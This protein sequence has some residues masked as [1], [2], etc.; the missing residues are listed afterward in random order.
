MW[1][2]VLLGCHQYRTFPPSHR[3]PLECPDP[4]GCRGTSRCC[5][6]AYPLE[7]GGSVSGTPRGSVVTNRGAQR[8]LSSGHR[9]GA[10]DTQTSWRQTSDCRE[11]AFTCVSADFRRRGGDPADTPWRGL[12]DEQAQ[13]L[14][15]GR[16]VKAAGTTPP[17]AAITEEKRVTITKHIFK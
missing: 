2:V 6:S 13:V 8:S 15:K 12:L 3:A 4:D 7:S 11:R 17:T 5:L 14:K 9:W 10:A 16:G 1:P